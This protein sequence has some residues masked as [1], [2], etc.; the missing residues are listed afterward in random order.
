MAYVFLDTSFFVA[1]LRP[2]DLHHAAAVA[3][4]RHH[5]ENGDVLVTSQF[6]L[7]ESGGGLSASA[8]RSLFVQFVHE[9]TDSQCLMTVSAS[10]S[11]FTRAWSLYA[12]R[13]D[14]EWSL[15]DCSSF[16]VMDEMGM[17]D[18]LTADHYFTQKGYRILLG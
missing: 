6:V 4:L 5:L 9:L 18:A 14:K 2:R 13:P 1:Y 10:E 3:Q 15:V 16:V 8:F 17:T 11:L 12:S 7:M